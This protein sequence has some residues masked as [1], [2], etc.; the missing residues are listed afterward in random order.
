MNA[1]AVAAARPVPGLA[2]YLESR[3]EAAFRFEQIVSYGFGPG[4]E[5]WLAPCSATPGAI[6]RFCSD[7]LRVDPDWISRLRADV[8]ASAAGTA[9]PLRLEPFPSGELVSLDAA[10]LAR[11]GRD[12]LASGRWGVVIFAG[13]AATRFWAGAASHPQAASIQKRFGGNAPKGL[14]PVCERSGRS[15]LDLFAGQMLA[16]A[17]ESGRMAPLVLMAGSAT[18]APLQEWVDEFLPPGYPRDMVRVMV[19]AE[20]PRLDMDGDLIVRPD[21]SLVFTGDG[22]GGVFRALLTEGGD[23]VTA[24]DWLRQRGVS[25]VVLHNVDNVAANALEPSR[26]GF[27][28]AGGF[29]MTLSAVPRLDPF[30]KVGIVALNAENRRVEVVEY[31][32]CPRETALATDVSG[33]LLFRPAHINSNLV[34]LDA[35]RPDLPPTLYPGKEV[36]VGGTLVPACSHEMLNQAL[37]GMIEPDRVGCLIL[38]RLEY[39]Q[40]TKSLE[41]VDSLVTTRQWLAARGVE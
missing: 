6:E 4:L 12:S 24:I 14:F 34:S 8:F 1:E 31:S 29:L 7:L 38:D 22:H 26:L 33:A 35:V 18:R 3:P 19:Q 9:A 40:P 17:A 11:A 28:L 2:G 16:S 23:G 32:V 37:A 39:F 10:A 41:G 5:K 30:E 20:H 27:H 25:D 13:G 15:F 36:D 21:G